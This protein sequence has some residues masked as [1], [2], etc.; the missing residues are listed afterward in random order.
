MKYYL[1]IDIGGTYIKHAIIDENYEL[2]DVQKFLTPTTLEDFLAHLD[3]LVER[4]Q[5]K[6]AGIAV[7]C[8]GDI[9]TKTGFVFRGGGLVSY[10]K[11]FPLGKHLQNKSNL[12]VTVVNDGDAA[13]IAEAQFGSLANLHC[14]VALILGSAVGTAVVS[15][16]ELVTLATQNIFSTGGQDKLEEQ[17]S[18]L[19][20]GEKIRQN[21]EFSWHGIETLFINSGSAV[22][23]V[24]RASELLHHS[25]PDGIAV[26]EAIE[27]GTNAEL[28]PMFE[29]YCRD[30]AYLMLNL[31]R[32]LTV[33]TFAIGGGISSQP[34][35]ISEIN[36]QYEI[37]Q[38]ST[39]VLETVEKVPIVACRFKNDA[40]LI[41][42]YRFFTSQQA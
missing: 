37:L 42:A 35:L 11:L 7:S 21:L 25:E 31:Q 4:Y 17:L 8:A 6:I 14:G 15:D 27:A 19:P 22:Q 12:P 2:S 28:M 23:F 24:N 41:G 29:H 30:I 10:L 39:P 38:T 5:T 13:G 33:E 1:T 20:I 32:I 16:G 40:N 3:E 36:H 34:A 26:F 18:V 9:N